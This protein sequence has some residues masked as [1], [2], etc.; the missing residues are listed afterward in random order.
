MSLENSIFYFGILLTK[1]FECVLDFIWKG[2][3]QNKLAGMFNWN[4]IKKSKVWVRNW[5]KFYR[6]NGFL[7]ITADITFVD[8][9]VQHIIFNLFLKKE[10][11]RLIQK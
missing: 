2:L 1:L 8:C 6:R 11:V 9:N 10:T 5:K 7:K 4:V 3:T